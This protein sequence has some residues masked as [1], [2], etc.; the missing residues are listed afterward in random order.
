MATAAEALKDKTRELNPG[1]LRHHVI[2]AAR[3]FKASWVELGK[4]LVQVR[5]EGLF[6]EWG[7]ETYESYC[8]KELHIRRQTAEK[9]ARSFSFLAKHEPEAVQTPETVQQAPSFEVV[10]V[11]AH[12]EERGQLSADEY[13]SIRDSIWNPE[14]PAAQLRREFAERYAPE[15][16]ES[17]QNVEWNRILG[18][19]RKLAKVLSSTEAIP[20]AVSERAQALVVDLES[21]PQSPIQ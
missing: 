17:P 13:R 18:L 16:S 21:L 1:T 8:L 9:L 3:K 14:K 15:S 4:L 20:Q 19:A 11:L 6:T 10:E 5:N 12:A 7:Y 2:Q